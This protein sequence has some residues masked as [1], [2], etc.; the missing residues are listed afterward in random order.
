MRKSG[1]FAPFPPEPS[2]GIRADGKPRHLC[3]GVQGLTTKCSQKGIQRRRFFRASRGQPD[4]SGRVSCDA[5]SSSP[6]SLFSRCRNR[7]KHIS[8]GFK[9]RG[10]TVDPI[11]DSVTG[12]LPLD[13][14]KGYQIA[15]LSL[16]GQ[17]SEP[18]LKQDLPLVKRLPWKS[19][20]KAKNPCR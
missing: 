20:E 9:K 5:L 18:R 12:L 6:P 13:I 14:P 3:L 1:V 7:C 4:G 19:I 16:N 10:V 8:K 11:V 15:E 2:T 17:K